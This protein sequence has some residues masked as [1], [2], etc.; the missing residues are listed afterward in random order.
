MRAWYVLKLDMP[1]TASHPAA[2]VALARWGLPGSALVIGSIAPDMPMFLPIPAMTHVAHTP[3]GIL[4]VDL[5]IGVAGFVLWQALFG[6]AL[7]A[8]A[9]APVRARLP[10]RPPAG[11]AH[12]FG[13]WKVR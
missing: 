8:V 9:P 10:D 2:V 6:P 12:H 7:V 1:F 13:R 5:A 11:L 3:L 4:T